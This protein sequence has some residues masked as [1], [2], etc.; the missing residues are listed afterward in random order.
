MRQGSNPVMRSA[1][2]KS[3][4]GKLVKIPRDPVKSRGEPRTGTLP[5]RVLAAVVRTPVFW[6]EADEGTPIRGTKL[7]AVPVSATL[8][9]YSGVS[10]TINALILSWHPA[11][12]ALRPRRARDPRLQNAQVRVRKYR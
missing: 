8:C 3:F 2:R 1:R 12:L 10:S 6:Y 9:R 7:A 11:G 5:R 4:Y